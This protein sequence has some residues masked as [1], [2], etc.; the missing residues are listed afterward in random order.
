MQ[1][2]L[3]TQPRPLLFV[4]ADGLVSLF[5]FPLGETPNGSYHSIDRPT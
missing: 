4:D 1:N 5:G 3:L 2:K